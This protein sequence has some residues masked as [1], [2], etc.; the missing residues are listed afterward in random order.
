MRKLLTISLHEKNG[1][2]SCHGKDTSHGIQW[3]QG[4]IV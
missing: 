4:V 3:K 2:V 1:K